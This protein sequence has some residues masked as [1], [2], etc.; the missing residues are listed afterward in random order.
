MREVISA[1]RRTDLPMRFPRWLAQVIR[2]GRAE[3][4]QPYSGQI[5]VVSLL[6]D[7]VHSIVL[8]SKDFGP[9]L[10]NE[11]GLRHALASYDQVFCHLTVTGLGGSAL[12]PNIPPWT[13]VIDQLAELVELA[14]DQRRVS[15]RFDPIVHWHDGE[16]TKSNFSLAPEIL[17]RC[18]ACGVRA[19]RISFATLYNKVLRRGW[20]WYDPP[21]SERLRMVREL[22][23]LAEPLG[24][25]VHACSERGL[26]AGGAVASKCIDGDLL[27]ELHPLGL[28][29]RGGKDSGQ[30]TECG[31]TPSVD[32]GSYA[33]RCP[34]G[35]RYCYANPV[36]G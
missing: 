3:V 13:R 31:C 4:L 29:A 32:I 18:A 8:W 27:A 10:A 2:A 34:N 22:L 23:A 28:P 5:R 19:V 11:G 16:E 33:M 35:C 20:S 24:L 26:Q 15:L 7:Q 25:S 36:I 12:E 6:P 17:R 30:R 14:G 21:L 1:S 9:L